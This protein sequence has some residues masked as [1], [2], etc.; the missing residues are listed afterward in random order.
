MLEKVRLRDAGYKATIIVFYVFRIFTG[1][2]CCLICLRFALLKPTLL[3]RLCEYRRCMDFA[4]D[5]SKQ[6]QVAFKCFGG[7][8]CKGCKPMSREESDCDGLSVPEAQ[9]PFL[10]SLR[11]ARSQPKP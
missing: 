1:R 4:E 6:F 2:V 5:R 10:L 7:Q 3:Q 9:L 11:Y 8:G